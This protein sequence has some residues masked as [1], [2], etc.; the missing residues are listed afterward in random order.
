MAER[1]HFVVFEGPEGAGK[2]TQL[3]RLVERLAQLGRQPLVTREPGGT[4]AGEAMR[5]VLLDPALQ[6]VPLAEFLL[7]SAARAQHVAEVVAPA[8]STGR[9]RAS[10]RVA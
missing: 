6:I 10:S 2:S 1:G 8:L 5:D 9:D 4:K 3:R 7:Y